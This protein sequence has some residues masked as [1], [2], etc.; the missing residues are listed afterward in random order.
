MTVAAQIAGRVAAAR[1]DS[2][3]F[4]AGLFVEEVAALAYRAAAAGP[5]RGEDRARA[6]EFAAHE[7]EHAA[8]FETL[9]FALT[10]PVREHATEADLDALL[11]DLR[12]AGRDEALAALADLEG[13]AI[14]A[15]QEMARRVEALDALRSV[16]AVT[17][18]GA[19]HLVVLR[20][21]LGQQPVTEAFE[22]GR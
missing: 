15:H 13:A 22:S 20:R 4:K 14:A 10:V 16:A 5:L 12:R 17:A 7:R 2:A 8:V 21:A 6:L 1:T 3:L 9:L 19:Q 18:G 11:P